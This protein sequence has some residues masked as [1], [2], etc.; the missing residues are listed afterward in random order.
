[1]C[2]AFFLVDVLG[3]KRSVFIGISLQA[4][5]ALYLTIYLSTVDPDADA[6]S[7]V[8]KSANEKRASIAAIVMIFISGIGWAL[9]INTIQYLVG[10]EVWP[11]ELRAMATSMIMA[12]HF[13]ELHITFSVT[14]TP[15]HI[16][17]CS[18]PIRL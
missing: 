12:L 1:M 13:G 17:A 3:R 15:T 18:Q 11:T 14:K 10:T 8:E 2:C 6:S 16:P 9:G 4:L 5:A 7:A